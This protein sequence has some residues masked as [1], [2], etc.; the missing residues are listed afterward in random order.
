[1]AKAIDLT[2]IG[3]RLGYAFEA[4]AST[5]PASFINIDNPKSIPSFNPEPNSLDIT[6]LNDL[7]W[8][9]YTS[10]LKDIG[11]AQGFGIGMSQKTL[12]EWNTMCDTTETNEA[13]GRRTWFVLY[14]PGLD[15]SFFFTGK[16]TKL[17]FPEAEV[18]SVWDATVYIA[19]T[20]EI[21][22]GTAINPTD[23]DSQSA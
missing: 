8:M 16:P 4:T 12:D 15:K 17:G 3:I 9:R 10:G 11:G 22:W 23:S 6:S 18:N 20:G 14:H 19:P 2:T 1:M 7:E 21:G 5:K 13:S